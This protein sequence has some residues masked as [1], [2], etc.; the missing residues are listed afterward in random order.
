LKQNGVRPT[1]PAVRRALENT[2]LKVEDIE[3]FA[4][5]HGIIQVERAF[6]YLMQHASLPT[7]NLGFTVTV[8]SQRGI[9]L[10]DPTHVSAPSDHGVGIEPVFPENT[11]TR[12]AS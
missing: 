6:D 9:Y 2:A 7:S 8:G 12:Y 3:V 10:R 11:G 4:Q 5:G 1:V